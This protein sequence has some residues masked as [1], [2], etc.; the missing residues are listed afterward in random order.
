MRDGSCSRGK[1]RSV[2]PA[3]RKLESYGCVVI[4]IVF[5]VSAD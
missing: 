3:I 2:Y 4:A 5:T 1:E